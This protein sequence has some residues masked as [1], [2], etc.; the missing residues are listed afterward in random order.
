M[1]DYGSFSFASKEE[2][3]ELSKRYGNPGKTQFW[4]DAGVPLVIDRRDGGGRAGRAQ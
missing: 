1:Y 4:I 3:I 2:V